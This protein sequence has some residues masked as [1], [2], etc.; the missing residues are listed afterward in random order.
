MKKIYLP[1]LMYHR[2]I[3]DEAKGNYNVS[4]KSFKEQMQYLYQNG[5]KAIMPEDI[6]GLSENNEMKWIM[7][8]FDDGYETDYT[9]A[10]PILRKYGFKG[11]SFVTT[12]FLGKDGYMK[13]EQ[14]HKLKEGEFSIQ[15]HTHTHP[16]L[17]G[18]T[19][20][21][22]KQELAISKTSIEKR[23]KTKV[24][25][26]SLP[27]GSYSKKVK[28]IALEQGYYYIF[29]SKPYINIINNSTIDILYRTLI[30]RGVTLE[31]FRN[32]VNLDK[33]TYQQAKLSYSLRNIIKACIGTKRYYR[34]WNKYSKRGEEKWY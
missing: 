11:V 32:I 5:F 24:I 6:L 8:T 33:R 14:V 22:I 15:S 21:N 2:I 25:S 13:W 1:I 23:L 26:L 31:K 9:L 7:I 27:G 4:I 19:E 34:L 20:R 18:T 3:D 30:T 16:L 17:K 10:L 12:G 28:N 29:N